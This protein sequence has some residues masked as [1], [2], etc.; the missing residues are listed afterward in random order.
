MGGAEVES[1]E[2]KCF[3]PALNALCKISKRPPY[4]HVEGTESFKKVYMKTM[5]KSILAGAVAL[6]LATVGTSQAQAGGWAVA[7]GVVG[8]LA[9][10][11]VIGATIA[12]AYDPA[13]YGYPAPMYRAPA[14]YAYSAPAY[15]A[16][17]PACYYP[18][19]V[20]VAAPFPYVYPAVRAGYA[21]GPRYHYGYGY[22]GY[23]RW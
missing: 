1:G 19:P 6:A 21:W 11:T 13:Y 18:R 15:P 17:A 5:T 20:V 10:G 4:W 8:G 23:R 22:R 3:R 14:Y 2:F 16:L 9:A 12:S 7:G